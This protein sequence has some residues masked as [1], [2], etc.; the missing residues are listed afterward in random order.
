MPRHI[1]ELPPRPAPTADDPITVVVRKAAP[2][3]IIPSHSHAWG[4]LAYPVSGAVCV[5]VPGSRWLVPPFR[6][7]WVPPGVD[8]ELLLMGKV[9]LQV[10][11][12]AAGQAGLPTDRCVV[13]EI[14]PLLRE[15]IDALLP[16]R[17]PQAERRRQIQALLLTEL[18]HAPTLDLRLPQPADRRLRALCD[19]LMAD[20]GDNAPLTEWARRVGASGRTLSRLFQ[21]ELGM[22]FGLW[23][24]QVRLTQATVLVAKGRPYAEIAAELGYASPSAFS[25]MFRRAFGCS[26]RQFY[27]ARPDAQAGTAAARSAR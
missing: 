12:V 25:A 19:A 27:A 8:H 3:S 7:V 2:D 14:S 22:S 18:G 21:E 11:H 26:P 24:Q 23:R 13:M 17:L 1:V 16:P 10:V 20:P 9:T 4:Q 6:A 5:D 15:L